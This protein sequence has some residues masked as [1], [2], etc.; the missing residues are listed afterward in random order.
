MIL[1][2]KIVSALCSWCIDAVD[3]NWQKLLP[4]LSLSNIQEQTPIFPMEVSLAMSQ[5]PI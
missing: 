2:A 1:A 3:N 4:L 5:D